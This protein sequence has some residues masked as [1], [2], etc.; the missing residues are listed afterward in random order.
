MKK[1]KT[2]AERVRRYAAKNRQK[3]WP[4]VNVIVPSEEARRLIVRLAA[5]MR[6][7]AREAGQG[8]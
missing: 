6:K 4:K 3:G 8:D 2:A 5:R 1:D 7:R